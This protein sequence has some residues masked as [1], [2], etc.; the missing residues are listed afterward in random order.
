MPEN[1]DNEWL[2][3]EQEDDAV[4]MDYDIASYPSDYTL[5]VINQMYEG[6]DIVIPSYQRRFVW[7]IKQASLLIDSFL[8]GL[9]VPPVFFYIDK[10]NK[11]VVIDG[12]Q[13]I[14]SV[15]YYFEGYFGDANASDKRTI[16]RLSGLSPNSPHHNKSIDELDASARRK[17]EHAVLRA[18]N[19][20]QLNPDDEGTSAYYIFERLNTGGTQLRPQEIR[21]CV[22]RGPF[23]KVLRKANEDANW[24]KLLGTSGLDKHQKDVELLLRVFA[25]V[26]AGDKYEKPMHKFLN[27]TMKKHRSGTTAE[28]KNFFKF[29]AKATEKM[30]H[31]QEEKPFHLRGPLNGSALDSVMSVLIKN[32]K[33]LDRIDIGGRYR[34]LRTDKIFLESTQGK[35]TDSNVVRSRIKRVEEVLLGS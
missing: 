29:F 10:D 25:L 12:Q 21:N 7:S 20:R 17:L 9:P 19:I 35:T 13:R 5:S 24:R 31:S 34:K 22:F 33:E 2:E 16:F 3:K 15:A 26:A 14:K 27:E 11:N 23:N 28:S 1:S 8:C 6:G 4:D 18:V 30:V 32:A